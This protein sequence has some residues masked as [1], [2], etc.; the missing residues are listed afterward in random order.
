[1]KGETAR[2]QWNYNLDGKVGLHFSELVLVEGHGRVSTGPDAALDVRHPLH[3]HRVPTGPC[4]QLG[5][6]GGNG[7]GLQREQGA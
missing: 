2:T 5:H 7:S 1:M 4:G 3:A 6:G